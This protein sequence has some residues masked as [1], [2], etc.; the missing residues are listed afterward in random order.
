M[1]D[2][3]R[4]IDRSTHCLPQTNL[5]TVQTNA[6]AAGLYTVLPAC[7]RQVL[8]KQFSPYFLAFTPHYNITRNSMFA[9]GG[10]PNA[11]LDCTLCTGRTHTSQRE[12]DGKKIKAKL[13]GKQQKLEAGDVSGGRAGAFHK[14]AE[15][16]KEK[17][18]AF[19]FF[20]RRHASVQI[21]HTGRKT[22]ASE[23]LRSGPV[24]LTELPS[25]KPKTIRQQAA[26]Q[27]I[28]CGRYNAVPQTDRQT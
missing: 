3:R 23:P 28:S 26:N 25:T 9:G 11:V 16:H 4:C 20:S 8:S 14:N 13:R 19:H 21:H 6:A 2:V 24:H 22:H 27:L 7:I 10:S 15:L 5:K 1:S 17:T 12:H 18:Q